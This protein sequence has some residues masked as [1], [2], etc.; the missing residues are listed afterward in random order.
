MNP[1]LERIVSMLRSR[2]KQALSSLI[3]RTPAHERPGFVNVLAEALAKDLSPETEAARQEIW[4]AIPGQHSFK[5]VV[6][7]AL[8]G[9]FDVVTIG[10]PDVIPEIQKKGLLRGLYAGNVPLCPCGRAGDWRLGACT[11]TPAE[12]R[13]HLNRPFVTKLREDGDLF[14]ELQAPA[15]QDYKM[16]KGEDWFA[17]VARVDR[18]REVEVKWELHR[19]AESMMD[20]VI[21]QLMMTPPEVESLKRVAQ[22][23]AAWA[24]HQPL[25]HPEDLLEAAQYRWPRTIEEYRK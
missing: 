16:P 8:V 17:L 6:E 19:D 14:I 18:A 23:I 21:G 12:I 4:A 5:R 22:A 10:H 25:I 13:R 9:G 11:C 2:E 1:R 15:P 24:E 3:S 7:I 20:Y